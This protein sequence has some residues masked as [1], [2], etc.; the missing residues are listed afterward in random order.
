MNAVLAG[1]MTCEDEP[2]D[3]L[4]ITHITYDV[5][6]CTVCDT[7]WQVLS[8]NEGGTAVN[9]V[10]A[11]GTACEN[12]PCDV[13]VGF[14]GSPDENGETSLDAMIMDG[15][16][17][18]NSTSTAKLCLGFIPISIALLSPLK[19]SELGLRTSK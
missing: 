7:A 6:V 11:G 16:V 4:F 19:V 12:E 5:C 15:F 2:C 9:A 10:L 18:N 8:S 17:F 14:G 13:T 1:G 3:E